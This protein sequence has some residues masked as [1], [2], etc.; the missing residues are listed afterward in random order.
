VLFRSGDKLPKDDD[1]ILSENIF[2]NYHSVLVPD[3]YNGNF[4]TD[5][6]GNRLVR[7]V[8]TKYIDLLKKYVDVYY[9]YSEDGSGYIKDDKG[10]P[11]EF[12]GFTETEYKTPELVKNFVT[13]GKD[14]TS[15]IG[16]GPVGDGEYSLVVFPEVKNWTD[17]NNE[18][19]AYIKTT[20]GNIFNRGPSDFR[21]ELGPINS[22]TKYLVRVKAF[23]TKNNRTL[24]PIKT[25]GATVGTYSLKDG[26]YQINQHIL[27]DIENTVYDEKTGYIEISLKC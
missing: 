25:A 13:N 2:Q 27:N 8:K 20:S 24:I 3:F 16:W 9:G 21:G 10:D 17:Y 6:R 5:C 22:D 4:V 26:K 14:F 1:G 19:K 18:P 7:S 15:N 23:H 11:I 12:Y